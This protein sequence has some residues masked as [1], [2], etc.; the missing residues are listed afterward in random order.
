MTIQSTSRT[1]LLLGAA[2]ALLACGKQDA[3]AN[4]SG[5]AAAVEPAASNTAQAAPVSGNAATATPAAAG[6]LSADYMV[7]KWSAMGEDCSDTIEFRKDGTAVTPMGPG[8]W[9]LT[10]DQLGMDFG[11]GSKQKPSTIKPIGP[12]RIEITTASGRKETERR[13]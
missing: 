12:D 1:I 4:A 7:G 3:T 10:G 8:K 6:A 5:N 2:A 13:C 9:T 11:D